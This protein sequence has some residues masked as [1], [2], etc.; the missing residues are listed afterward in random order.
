M[1]KYALVE[2]NGMFRVAPGM[3]GN[4]WNKV[5]SRRLATFSASKAAHAAL[6]DVRRD[7]LLAVCKKGRCGWYTVTTVIDNRES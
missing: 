1:S 6:A 7:T 3:T 4:S 2:F 5:G